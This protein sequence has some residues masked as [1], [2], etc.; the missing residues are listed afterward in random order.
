MSVIGEI[1]KQNLRRLINDRYDGVVQR[2]AKDCN[3]QHSQ[4]W[5]VLKDE[6]VAGQPRYV[7]EKLARK[8]E[9]AVGLHNGWMDQ[10]SDRQSNDRIVVLAERISKLSE[11]D[12]QTVERM[13]DGLSSLDAD[14]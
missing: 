14:E 7:G 3:I 4:L 12:R 2:L 6:P 10:D 5:R 11:A 8:I 1:R 13:I 9:K